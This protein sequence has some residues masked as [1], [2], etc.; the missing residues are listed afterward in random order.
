MLFK[1]LSTLLLPLTIFGLLMTTSCVDGG[2]TNIEID[3]VDGPHVRL[4]EDNIHITMVFENL[5]V[6]GG[7]RYVIPKYPNSY[8]EIAPDLATGALFMSIDLSLDDVLDDGLLLL[9]PQSLPGGRALPGIATGKLPAVAF[10]IEQFYGVTFYV[11]PEVFGFFMPVDL[12]IENGIVSARYYMDG[13]RAGTISLVGSDAN[14]ENSGLL[15]LL[16]FKGDLKK[17]LKRIADYY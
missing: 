16:D 13:N 14:G 10:T 5:Q 11:G 1:K 3:G 4:L 6:D 12:G 7:L 2:G 15:L 9:D 17:K 8:I